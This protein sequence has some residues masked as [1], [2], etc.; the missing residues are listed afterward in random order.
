M[1]VLPWPLRW[2]ARLPGTLAVLAIA[3]ASVAAQAAE[4]GPLPSDAEGF[5][6]LAGEWQVQHRRLEDPWGERE[7]WRQSEGSAS[8]RTLVDGLVS[9]EELRDAKGAPFGGA[10]RTFDRERRVWS[11]SWVGVRDG[12][13]QPGV[14]G[15][16]NGPVGTFITPDTHKDRVILAKG[17]WRRVS[18]DEFTWEQFFSRDDGAT[19]LLTWHM[20]F[21]RKAGRVTP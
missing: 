5:Y 10:V 19:W 12:I 20:R 11:D 9:V 17:V 6:F 1:R 7:A 3:F 18:A 8:F 14:I 21:Q 4:P 2:A 16:F 15:R 13:L